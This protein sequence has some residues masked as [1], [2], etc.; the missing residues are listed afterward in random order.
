MR[1]KREGD[2]GGPGRPGSDREFPAPAV[3]RAALGRHGSPIREA[4]ARRRSG[5]ARRMRV[6][7]RAGVVDVETAATSGDRSRMANASQDARAYSTVRRAPGRV[8]QDHFLVVTE[9]RQRVRS[10]LPRDRG[11]IHEARTDTQTTK[12]APGWP[13]EHARFISRRSRRTKTSPGAFNVAGPG[14]SASTAVNRSNMAVG[15]AREY[16][17]KEASAVVSVVSRNG[18]LARDPA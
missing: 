7:A 8:Q 1:P 2:R 11:Q 9:Y 16:G 17:G 4:R 6:Q 14:G 18:G 13:A 15:L 10:C 3:E 12:C 5:A